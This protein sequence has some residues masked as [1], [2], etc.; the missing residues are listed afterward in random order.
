MAMSA[1]QREIAC[2]ALDL[3]TQVLIS[4][5]E[6]GIS[7]INGSIEN[8]DNEKNKDKEGNCGKTERQSIVADTQAGLLAEML[9][10]VGFSRAEVFARSPKVCREKAMRATGAL[11]DG[12]SANQYSMGE[13][14]IRMQLCGEEKIIENRRRRDGSHEPTR[15]CLHLRCYHVSCPLALHLHAL[16]QDIPHAG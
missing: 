14:R 7:N 8:T 2:R 6:D 13:V 9:A 11:V 12:H 3:L 4:S 1:M 15:L 10:H 5:D 16:P